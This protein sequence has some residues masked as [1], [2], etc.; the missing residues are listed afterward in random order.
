M[1]VEGSSDEQSQTAEKTF[2]V[3]ETSIQRGQ[4]RKLGDVC[5]NQRKKM[6]AADLRKEKDKLRKREKRQSEEYRQQERENKKKRQWTEN[7]KRYISR[8]NGS[9]KF[10]DS[11]KMKIEQKLWTKKVI[12]YVNR[13]N[14]NRKNTNIM[15]RNI[16]KKTMDK[17]G[18]KLRKQKK[19]ESDEYRNMENA[20]RRQD[21]TFENM[22]EKFSKS[23]SAGP[24]YVCTSCDQLWY[25]HSVKL[26][27]SVL[28]KNGELLRRCKTGVKSVQDEEWMC[29]TCCR[30]VT[31]NKLP[32]LSK[33]NK[34]SFL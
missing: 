32:P 20:R 18:D 28:S 5:G 22:I 11:M 13:R 12:S 15:K 14:D 7:L 8:K 2:S 1:S 21:S 16:E 27:K 17:E 30:Y 25:R 31:A 26:A 24:Q 10:T 23:V 6:S 29:E 9:Q 19:R 34:T 3:C 4:K 33:A